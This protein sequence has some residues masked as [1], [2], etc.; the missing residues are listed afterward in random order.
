MGLIGKACIVRDLGKM[1]SVAEQALRMLDPRL[2]HPLMGRLP[3]RLPE[4]FR[5]LR[6]RHPRHRS[7]LLDTQPTVETFHHVIKDVIEPG[8]RGV[9]LPA[10]GIE[11][12]NLVDHAARQ[13]LR[14]A[15]W[16]PGLPAL[17]RKKSREL[18]KLD[19]A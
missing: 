13:R 4:A 9:M 8:W 7:K 16:P 1:C 18:L 19:A 6:P 12:K 10:L 11:M 5:E 14:I 17:I 15:C 2:H 3:R